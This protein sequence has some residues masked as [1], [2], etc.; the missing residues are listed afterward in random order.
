MLITDNCGRVSGQDV[1]AI[2]EVG[3]VTE[4]LCLALR[5]EEFIRLVKTLQSRVVLRSD[6]SPNR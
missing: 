2:E 1:R 5:T 4:A 3:D 6:K